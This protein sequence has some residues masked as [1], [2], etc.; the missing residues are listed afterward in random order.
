ME[1]TRYPSFLFNHFKNTF[2]LNLGNNT[3]YFQSFYFTAIVGGNTVGR[4]NFNQFM[5][6]VN[7]KDGNFGDEES[8]IMLPTLPHVK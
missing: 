8:T 6:F 1:L 5:T 3:T 7:Q 4:K 2:S